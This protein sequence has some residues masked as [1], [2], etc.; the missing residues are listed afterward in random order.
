MDSRG[1]EIYAI[2]PSGIPGDMKITKTLEVN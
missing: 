2:I 1:H